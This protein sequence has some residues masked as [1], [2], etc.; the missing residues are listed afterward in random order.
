[1][2]NLQNSL[3]P[4]LFPSAYSVRP[5][6]VVGYQNQTSFSLGPVGY[7]PTPTS[8]VGVPGV[9]PSLY[10]Q[11]PPLAYAGSMGNIAVPALSS[12]LI[13][14]PLATYVP[15][16]NANLQQALAHQPSSE[17]QQLPWSLQ[18]GAVP[19][20]VPY[21]QV[22]P[23][24][25]TSTHQTVTTQTSPDII[26]EN[27]GSAVQE[28]GLRGHENIDY[29]AS[30]ATA[31]Q[32]AEPRPVSPEN[33]RPAMPRQNSIITSMP[34]KL[35]PSLQLRSS[36]GSQ[37]PESRGSK[38]RLS[39][40]SRSSTSS[41]A[42][43]TTVSSPVAGSDPSTHVLPCY[44]KPVKR[45]QCLRCFKKVYPMEQ[46]GPIKEVMYHK[47]CFTCIACGLQLNLKNFSH[48]TNDLDDLNVFCVA[49]RPREKSVS[50][51][52]T[53][54]T[55]ARALN[56][57]KLDKVNEQI[58]GDRYP[59]EVLARSFYS[60]PA[61]SAFVTPKENV[62]YG[63]SYDELQR[64]RLQNQREAELNNRAYQPP[65]GNQ[66]PQQEDKLN[67]QA[68][69]MPQQNQTLLQHNQQEAEINYQAFQMPPQNQTPRQQNQQEAE[70]N[71]QAY[72]MPP[73]NQ[74]LLQQNQQEAEM[75]Y[76]AYPMPLQSQTS[77]QWNES[78]VIST[79]VNG[80]KSPSFNVRHDRQVSNDEVFEPSYYGNGD[81][82]RSPTLSESS[83]SSST[84]VTIR[85]NDRP[86]M[87]AIMRELTAKISISREDGE[88]DSTSATSIMRSDRPSNA[89]SVSTSPTRLSGGANF[90]QEDGISVR[91]STGSNHSGQD[92]I[93]LNS[94]FSSQGRL[95]ASTSSLERSD[96]PSLTSS[97][98]GRER[99]ELTVV[100]GQSKV[101]HCTVV[102]IDPSRYL[103]K[104]ETRR[105]D[106]PSQY[107]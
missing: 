107:P 10:Q 58:R 96:R 66:T 24:P 34:K 67:Y 63:M 70:M 86:S 89:S 25:A 103:P 60:Q 94:S 44:E 39:F 12:G 78:Y 72:K 18:T 61:A 49:H 76:P 79:V 15:V 9:Q 99:S 48:N 53:A 37:S 22:L 35:N 77:L 85:R 7:A 14:T 69:Q 30:A 6:G 92:S 102:P 8:G 59:S 81:G 52:A 17:G 5:Q 100:L 28:N 1:M 90:R 51:D 83:H 101:A 50:V 11:S 98:D 13:Q 71:Y 75:N 88:P 16:P 23:M 4:Y 27:P 64:Q 106:R 55:I 56:V 19:N 57:P 2:D 97:M 47:N 45:D 36:S 46:V 84:S 104:N 29:S 87:D 82:R 33:V 65:P 38:S 32:G 73:Q 95:M 42:S 31:P 93:D 20:V 91:S 40:E 3:P 80:D 54:I 74:T 105:M 68:Y 43:P 21:V 26:P 41:V 62:Y